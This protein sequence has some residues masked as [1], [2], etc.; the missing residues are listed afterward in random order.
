M[1][2]WSQYFKVFG[3]ILLGI[4]ISYSGFSQEK[5]DNTLDY[6]AIKNSSIM[7]VVSVNTKNY[8][9]APTIYKNGIV[10]IWTQKRKVG[11]YDKNIDADFFD[12]KYADLSNSYAEP[13]NFS[14]ELND[15]YH[16]S[17]VCFYDDDEKM[18]LALN[19]T[20]E[21]GQDGFYQMNL[22]TAQK[23]TGGVWKVEDKFIYNE[24][25]YTIYHPTLS[26]DGRVLVFASNMP[27]GFGKLDLYF[28]FK[29]DQVWGVPINMG[30][31]VNTEG[32]DAFP[33]LHKD[34]LF[35]AS[36]SRQGYGGYDIYAS[37]N[38][39][40]IWGFPDNVGEPINSEKDDLGIVFS[41]DGMT[42]YF[43]SSR[44]GG[45]GL[46]DIYKISLPSSVIYTKEVLPPPTVYNDYVVNI[47]DK[48]SR[49]NVPEVD[50]R[51]FP[52]DLNQ[53]YLSKSKDYNLNVLE[54]DK[55]TGEI[56]VK[57]S[58]KML[59]SDDVIWEK[60]DG[61]GLITAKLEE[62]KSYMMTLSKNGFLEDQHVVV[63]AEQRSKEILYL[64]KK[65]V[66]VAPK[67]RPKPS[68]K[69]KPTPVVVV[70][71]TVEPT[72]PTLFI[73]TESGSKVVFENIYYDLNSANIKP[74]A[75]A[76]LDALAAAMIDNPSMRV[77]LES[78]TDV[79]GNAAYNK[80]LSQERAASAKN[81]LVKK[82]IKSNRVETK[83]F[84]EERVRNH[85]A[86]GVKCSDKE[87][88]YN[89]RT[90]VSIL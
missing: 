84:G 6:D 59:Q 60:T 61:R 70:Q 36:D 86:Q 9:T 27:G 18:L 30:P 68:P 32:N 66:V 23:D 62:G 90:E 3:I 69:P 79:R 1:K 31:Y 53:D 65:K 39:K 85:C 80:A 67:P 33:R 13:I 50:V 82:G 46:D 40:G 81:Y 54:H 56:T 44:D 77:Q 7:N 12:L 28:C 78:H 17:P 75:A 16:M 49:S 55:V 24:S 37:K 10:Y 38:N 41:N 42:G 11:K 25:N 21:K 26:D 43:T 35:F 14:E 20:E 88:A 63:S 15:A 57:M 76:E 89:R 22:M 48:V 29:V 19:N 4:L 45:V 83:G 74:G 8:E 71:E 51:F 64:E 87:H 5:V 52:I 47:K 34:W 58:P 2:N 73:P 72:E